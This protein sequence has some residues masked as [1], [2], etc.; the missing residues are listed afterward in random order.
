[1]EAKAPVLQDSYPMNMFQVHSY[2][3]ITRQL[4][5]NAGVYYTSSIGPS[6]VPVAI[7]TG[8][9]NPSFIRA[10]FNIVWNPK[11]NLALTLGVQNAFDEQHV[12]STTGEGSTADIRRAV[13]AEATWKY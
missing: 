8:P 4:Q 5:L 9:G 3:D 11:P 7:G 6:G 10:D 13:Y 12:E 1:M 2:W